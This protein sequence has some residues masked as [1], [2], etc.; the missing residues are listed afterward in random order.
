[1]IPK[2]IHYCWFGPYK[3]PNYFY[4]CYKSWVRFFH[5]FEIIEWNESNTDLSHPFLIEAIKKNKWAFVSDFVRIQKLNE[6]GGIYLDTDMLFIKPFDSNFLKYSFFIGMEDSHYLNG[7]I[8]GA[9]KS[10]EF[11]QMLYRYYL[12]IDFLDINKM[13][14]PIILN[15]VF[16]NNYNKNPKPGLCNSGLILPF[17]I[18]YPLPFKLKE[19]HWRKFL[20]K[21]SLAVHLWA[22][23]W[24]VTPE[25]SILKSIFFKLRYFVSKYY[26]PKS[27][28]KYV[29]SI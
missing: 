2:I 7:A 28:K 20:T 17:P 1:M 11:I 21:E 14:I 4:L 23:S 25:S 24:L 13:T 12:S 19:F 10:D 29:D 27:I 6:H 8:L 15:L 9:K 22:G 18:F 5:G 26:V 3:K 16:I